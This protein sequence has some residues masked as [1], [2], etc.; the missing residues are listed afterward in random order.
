MISH[1]GEYYIF[2]AFRILGRVR[3]G[4]NTRRLTAALKHELAAI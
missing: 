4:A 3:A 1:S 2:Y